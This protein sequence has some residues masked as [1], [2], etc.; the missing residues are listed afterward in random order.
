LPFR[1]HYEYALD[2]KNRLNMPPP[3]RAAFSGGMVLA[4][5][6]EPCM[7]I[8]TPAGFERF[9]DSFLAE[10]NPVSSKRRKLVSYFAGSSFD[11]ELDA[12]GRVTLRPSLKELAS[13]ERDVVVVGA[14]D[15][16]EVWDRERWMADQRRL[17]A[18][19]VEIAES[20]GHPS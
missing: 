13:I 8:W 2:A 16:V 17:D 6:L 5:W 20:L 10:L 19:I 4:K 11:A 18:E 1:G 7:A 15:H 14:L 3:F 9:T 12:A